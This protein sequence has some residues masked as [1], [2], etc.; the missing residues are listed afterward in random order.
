M[1]VL[2]LPSA[3][4][5]RGCQTKKRV[6]GRRLHPVCRNA[7]PRRFYTRDRYSRAD[8]AHRPR[9]LENLGPAVS[10]GGRDD[11]C[12]R[13][14]APAELPQI[15]QHAGADDLGRGAK[16]RRRLHPLRL[17]ARRHAWHVLLH[18]HLS[19]SG[20]LCR[21]RRRVRC[22][23]YRHIYRRAQL[24]LA[25][26]GSDPDHCPD[27]ADVARLHPARG[28]LPCHSR[29]AFGSLPVGDQEVREHG[30]RRPL[31]GNIGGEEGQ[32]HRGALQPGPQ[33]HAARPRHARPG[34]Q[35]RGRQ[36]GGCPPPVAELAR[37]AARPVDAFDAHARRRRRHA[38]A[39][40]LPLHRGAADAGVA[41]RP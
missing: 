27:L 14:R 21:D 13:Y 17:A 12:R 20:S 26:H 35:G 1:A 31:C 25:A 39:Q 8:A 23:R 28:F 30:A 7:V 22:A 34:W 2:G 18:G 40:G 32:Q 11:D 6:T 16:A 15:Q 5:G 24:R 29:P 33:Y 38:C 41:R 10:R 19:R 36:C 37:R 9:L 4:S 3:G